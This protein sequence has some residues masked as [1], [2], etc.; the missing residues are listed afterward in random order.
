MNEQVLD[1]RV[2]GA[3]VAKRWL[4]IVAFL[5]GGTGTGLGLAM[6][7]A[8]T[9][10]T[11]AMVLLPP[12]GVDARGNPTRNMVTEA[13]VATG[14][15]VLDR[16]GRALDPPA[17]AAAL[18]GR[19]R[20]EVIT[21]DI[22]EM[23]ASG[24]SA[25]E[26]KLLADTVAS[27]YVAT[28]NALGE[29]RVDSAVGDLRAHVA[30]L[31]RR[32][33]QIR[34]EMAAN[35]SRLGGLDPSS[36]EAGNVNQLNDTLQIEA[37]ELSR[38][39]ADLN[40]RI[41]EA[42]V[43]ESL[44]RQGTRLLQPAPQPL[45]PVRPRPLVNAAVGALA[46]LVVG[47]GA[48]LA[49]HLRSR[50]RLR[51]RDE[52]AQA[53]GGPVVASLAVAGRRGANAC[54]ALLGEWEPAVTETW[55]LRQALSGLD[56]G[57]GATAGVVIVVLPGD[58]A[59]SLLAAKLAAFAA[60]DGM[61]T[62]LVIAGH[63][64]M[65]SDLETACSTGSISG[66]PGRPGLSV[67]T[68]VDGLASVQLPDDD[69]LTIV[70]TIADGPLDLP[71]PRHRVLP[72]LAVSS[73]FA[74]ADQLASTALA[75]QSAGD[76]IRAVLLA[77]PDPSDRSTG[78]IASLAVAHTAN[79]WSINGDEAEVTGPTVANAEGRAVDPGPPIVAGD[80]AF[81]D[82]PA[83]L[84]ALRRRRGL[85]ATTF[86]LGLVAT[87]GL[88]LAFP[89][90][91]SARA[92]VLVGHPQGADASRSVLT[93]ISLAGTRAL[94]EAAATRLGGDV[95]ADALLDSLAAEAASSEVIHLTVSGPTSAEAVRRAQVVAESFLTFR[96][97][98]VEGQWLEV[99][100]TLAGRRE[101]VI[102]ELSEIG[103]QLQ[104]QAGA[105]AEDD[106]ESLGVLQFR[107]AALSS[108]LSILNQQIE[109][110]E[111]DVA[112]VVAKS[113]I[114]DPA[115][116]T[117]NSSSPL[118]NLAAGLVG[119]LCLGGGWIVFREITDTRVRRRE[120]ITQALGAPVTLSIERAH[121]WMPAPIRRR[122]HV[123]KDHELA[124]IVAHLNRTLDRTGD[125]ALAVVPIGE[126]A[127]A[128]TV[129]ALAAQLRENGRSTLLVDFTDDDAVAHRLGVTS[130]QIAGAGGEVRPRC[131][132]VPPDVDIRRVRVLVLAPVDPDVDATRL[133]SWT[134]TAVVVIAA[135]RSTPLALRST[136][137][138]LRAAGIDL[139]SA[140]VVDA[141][142]TDESVGVLGRPTPVRAPRPARVGT[143]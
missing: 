128:V 106:F 44:R 133:A 1:L 15:D 78:R 37:A 143:R 72:V 39:L 84:T 127:L 22:L 8:P 93:D 65:L 121:G 129:A 89:G 123:P 54:R 120:D 30:E 79:G 103:D 88:S 5:I 142:P 42:R 96:R 115:S 94:A 55:T 62:T 92:T 130:E 139:D 51:S 82:V 50:R 140:V 132:A 24:A 75:W 36:G 122:S 4:V 27:A 68:S 48:S 126:E 113:R 85:L 63:H 86:V 108:E 41:T 131:V 77:N 47:S 9:Y 25:P 14:T 81:V 95:T 134:S 61:H 97:D 87:M 102:Q 43:T 136:A 111:L 91:S 73:G 110:G 98:Q 83:L 105:V 49:L 57:Y 19:V 40:E 29:D 32:M 16:A 45:A 17:G 135:G 20:V 6:A 100:G 35:A 112:A 18:V 28:Q 26:A 10:E 71:E 74:S 33:D 13:A 114:V 99:A 137:T 138:L 109:R 56:A 101:E 3:G 66:F 90:S 34:S 11:G 107:Q 69:Q 2:V 125:R 124:R 118:L 59:A 52:I 21:G 12:A 141:D 80:D 119:G 53:V 67:R 60:N 58:R 38:E 70:L 116:A 117:D 31:N 64:P 76:P 23:R 7:Q 104:A 46:G